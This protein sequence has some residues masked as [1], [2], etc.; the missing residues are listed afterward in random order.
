MNISK[1]DSD[2][3]TTPRNI[4]DFIHQYNCKKEIID[5]NERHDAIDITTNK[6]FFPNNYIVNIFLFNTVVISLLFMTLT[7]YLFCK[8]M[9][10]STLVASLALEQVKEVG[11]VTAQKK[12][13]L[14]AK[15]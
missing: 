10:L 3:L 2:L 5:L 4:K 14:N 11:T 8:H 1:F 12:S 9:K 13:I 6:N 7:I 15:F